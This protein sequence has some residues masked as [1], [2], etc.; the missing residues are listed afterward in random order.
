MSKLYHKI[1]VWEGFIEGCLER[2]GEDHPPSLLSIG[3]QK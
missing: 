1:S 3:E 2:I